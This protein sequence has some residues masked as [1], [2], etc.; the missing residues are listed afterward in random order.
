MVRG[1]DRFKKYFEEFPDSYI[2]IGGTACDIIIEEAG[3]NPRATKDIDMILVVEALNS[4]FVAKFW[5]FIKDGNYEHK[6]SSADKRRYYRFM[7]PEE[8]GYPFQLELFARNLDLLDTGDDAYLTPIPVA[9]ELSSLSAI[10]LDDAYYYFV[11]E[12][13]TLKD[14]LHLANVESLI[15]LKAKAYLDIADRVSRGVKEDR[16]K[17]RKHAADVFRLAIMLRQD[18]LFKLPDNI[19]DDLQLFVNKIAE[20]LPDKA[21][22]KEMGLQNISAEMVLTQII[23]SFQLKIV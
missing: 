22:F 20:D 16:K 19:R 10:L 14:N 21:I 5:Q 17:L 9:D 15:C 1:L 3:L 13:S 18:D 11:N 8:K 23:H 7:K 4:D 12:H 6:E 2:I